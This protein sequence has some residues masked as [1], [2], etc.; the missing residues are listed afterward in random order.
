MA[1]DFQLHDAATTALGAA[2]DAKVDSTEVDKLRV[3]TA[4]AYAAL[5]TKDSRTFYVIVG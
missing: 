2:L 4:A 1:S 5:T 3:M